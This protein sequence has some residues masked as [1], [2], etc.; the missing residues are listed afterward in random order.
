MKK[1]IALAVASAFV[2]PAFAADVT[3]SGDVEYVY[4]FADAGE[5][6]SS[7]D[8]DVVVTGSEE[9]SNGMTV[10]ASLEMDGSD[11]GMASDSSLTIST[12]MMTISVGD[13]VDM[14]ALQIDEKSD[15]AEK[16]GNGGDLVS[17][18]NAANHNILVTINPTENLTVMVSRGTTTN[19]VATSA[20]I[21]SYAVQY[22]MMGATVGY[23]IASEEGQDED[24]SVLSIGY[25]AGPLSIGYESME[26]I[27]S[28]QNDDATNVGASYNMGSATLFVES[29]E[30]KDAAAGTKE[31]TTA[32]GASYAVGNLN[33]YV[34][35][36]SVST[37]ATADD[38][39]TI[40]GVE[41]KF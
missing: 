15:K 8:Q 18:A 6:M 16:G 17:T 24:A 22:S 36:N 5:A 34:V 26:N 37:S 41:Y 39:Q 10:S 13:A 9:L 32:Y 28:V 38:D 2:A 7:G 1:I 40:V 35:L 30:T 12:G 20:N 31:E 4:T 33:T 3:V 29:G 25:T 27:A 19:D 14:A 23:A 11:S 21:D